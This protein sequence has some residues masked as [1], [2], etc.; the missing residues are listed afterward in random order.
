MVPVS[1]VFP[2][3]RRP[4]VGRLARRVLAGGLLATAL[5]APALVA[6][7]P[8][9]AAGCAAPA[10]ATAA[11]DADAVFAGTV[12]AVTIARDGDARTVTHRVRVSALW[13]GSIDTDD[14]RVVT[15]AATPYGCPLGQ[16]KRDTSY[17]FFATSDG[18]VWSAAKDDGTREAT[19]GLRRALKSIYGEP[20]VPVSPDP[21]PLVLTRVADSTP[22]SASRAAAPGAALVLVGLLGLVLVRR[23]RR[24]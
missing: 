3:L 19:A 16:L 1:A 23:L 21:S 2:A 18:E 4:S 24:G 8:A 22:T 6:P 9:S 15:R 14:V 12:Q 17:V 20:R 7:A 11:R 10:V 13:K 5:S